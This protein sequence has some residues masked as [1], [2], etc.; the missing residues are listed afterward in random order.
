MS[1]QKNDIDMQQLT[2]RAEV[3]AE[4]NFSLYKLRLFLYALLG[5]SFIFGILLLLV[6][7]VGG[8]VAVAFFSTAL[9]LFLVKKKLIF[10]LIPTIWILLRALWVKFEAPQGY[11][12]LP[13]DY[14]QLF[15]KIDKIR[16][17]LKA[18]KIHQ[19]ILTK[20]LN[21]AV[22]QT[23]R[24]GIFGYYKN[25]VILG[26][27][28]LLVLSSQQAEAVLAH[29][30]G[31][32]SGNH[33]RFNGWIYRVRTTWLRIMYAFHRS[34][35]LG[36]RLMRWFFDWY[37][38]R[39]SAYSF[40]LAR[41]NEYEADAVSSKLTNKQIT[42][43][44]LVNVHVAGPYVDENYWQEY[45]RK[46]D[47]L[48]K[49]DYL[50]WNG[51]CEFLGSHARAEEQ[52]KQRL[53][54]SIEQPTSYDDT[55]PSLHDRLAAL[56]VDLT[57][58]APS[59]LTAAEVWLGDKFDSII[60]DFDTDWLSTNG[61]R[62]QERYNY[63]VTSKER[64]AQLRKEGINTF[65]DDTL[66]EKAGLEHEFGSQEQAA[67][68]YK[69]YQQR[70]PD[71]AVAAFCLGRYAYEREDDELLVQMKK[72]ITQPNLVVD[73][74]R[75][76]YYYLLK[77]DR[78]DEAEWWKEKANRQIEIDEDANYERQQLSVE[79]T[80][81]APTVNDEVRNYIATRLKASRKVKQAWIAEKKVEYYPESPAL[82]LAVVLKGLYWNE[83]SV[84]ERLA[85]R[86]E[87][88]CAFFVVPKRG[89]HKKLAKKIIAIGD[90]LV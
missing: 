17:K 28:L 69:L 51:L 5:Y 39:F 74:C 81:V 22:V 7:L 35:S 71:N 6:G 16:A 70:Y 38:P 63:V 67:N 76:A 2:A 57:L 78:A 47:V 77:H 30:L 55:H 79:D 18:P 36:A 24:L 29:E 26:L 14:P 25:T 44:A 31:H 64:L 33:S 82:A 56:G 53:Q 9:L 83:D 89:D 84:T 42:G 49:P 20:E 8:L 23:P 73:A 59:E 11:T 54:E 19:V 75:Y 46:A 21:A 61:E 43:E 32:L 80:I 45:F 87:L 52:L 62:W 37:S 66:W 68:A 1:A 4:N 41:I 90:Q 13:N 27:E 3:L 86:L 48:P 85:Q 65:D 72:A 58:P 50:P 15:K 40:A 10:V 60:E 34:H 12:L 88:D